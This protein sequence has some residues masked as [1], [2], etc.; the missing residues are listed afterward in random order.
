[1]VSKILVLAIQI[2]EK[3]NKKINIYS[4][5]GK[6]VMKLPI[7]KRKWTAWQRANYLEA[8]KNTLLYKSA[9]DFFFKLYGGK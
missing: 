8:K 3:K 2:M 5:N 1:M 9:D 7:D 6:I 4:S